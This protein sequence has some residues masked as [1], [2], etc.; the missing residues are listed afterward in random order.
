MGDG[1]WRHNLLC[2][3]IRILGREF[4]HEIISPHM[5]REMGRA[6]SKH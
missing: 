1:N 4:L 6:G 2:H 3:G 5:Y